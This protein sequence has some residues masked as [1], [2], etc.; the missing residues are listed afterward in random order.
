MKPWTLDKFINNV[1]DKRYL[2]TDS[3]TTLINKDKSIYSDTPEFVV[4]ITYR[5][6]TGMFASYEYKINYASDVLDGGKNPYH[7]RT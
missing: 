1:M 4:G 7:R 3:E 6:L 2:V 5:A